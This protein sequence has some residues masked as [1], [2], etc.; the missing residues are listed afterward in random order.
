[1][2]DL[3]KGLATPKQ[4]QKIASIANEKNYSDPQE[5]VSFNAPKLFGYQRPLKDL[6]QEEANQLILRGT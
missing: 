5:F 6:T 2:K 1:M 4:L 3:S